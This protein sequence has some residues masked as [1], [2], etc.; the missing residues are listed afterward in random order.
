[1]GSDGGGCLAG[2]VPLQ[3]GGQ[4]PSQAAGTVPGKKEE[5]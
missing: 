1:M 4:A 2:G 3:A 5:G